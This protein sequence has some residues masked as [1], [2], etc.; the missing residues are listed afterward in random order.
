MKL[1]TLW[2]VGL[3]SAQITSDTHFYGQSPPVYPS[4]ECHTI[5]MY[6]LGFRSQSVDSYRTC[7]AEG[8]GLGD[9]KTAYT[10]AKHL[11]SELS[12]DEKVR[13]SESSE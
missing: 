11:V 2:V 4:R 9:W 6:Y 3:A 1:F 5:R 10:K 13:N 7:I 12:I 8:N